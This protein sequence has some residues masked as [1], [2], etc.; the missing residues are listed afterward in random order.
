MMPLLRRTTCAC[1]AL[2]A[3]AAGLAPDDAKPPKHTAEQLKETNAAF[4]KLGVET[5]AWAY[6]GGPM[7]YL[8]AGVTDATL[9]KLPDVPFGYALGL[10]GGKITDAGLKE[11]KWHK[12]LTA[13]DLVGTKVTDAGLKELKELKFLTHL[14]LDGTKATAAGV[15]DYKALL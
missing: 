12:T 10:I 6:G 5:T 1:L 11:L 8:P 15:K 4:A 2:L 9:K 14:H 7:Y 13:L 3:A